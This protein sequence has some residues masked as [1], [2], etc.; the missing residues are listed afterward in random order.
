MAKSGHIMVRT[1]A[2]NILRRF[3]NSRR[4]LTL[5]AAASGAALGPFAEF[6]CQKKRT[7]YSA[8]PCPEK[9]LEI[10]QFW[11]YVRSS[12]VRHRLE[13]FPELRSFQFLAQPL[14]RRRIEQWEGG[15]PSQEAHTKASEMC[16]THGISLPPSQ[17]KSTRI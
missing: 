11:G 16:P 17:P 8:H 2:Q 3:S 1:K 12:G 9:G 10:Q 4:S 13:L 15:S 5:I 14:S 6:G 7:Y